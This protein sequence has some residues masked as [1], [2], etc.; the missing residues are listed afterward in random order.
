MPTMGEDAWSQ[1]RYRVQAA[2]VQISRPLDLVP[3]TSEQQTRKPCFAK[4]A[5]DS[6]QKRDSCEAEL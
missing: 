3:K 4:K 2:V 6:A 5:S 1:L